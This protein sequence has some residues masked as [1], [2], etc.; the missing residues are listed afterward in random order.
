MN[1]TDAQ[2]TLVIR[3]H[4]W[5]GTG[6]CIVPGSRLS[7]HHTADPA[8]TPRRE[9]RPIQDHWTTSTRVP[10]IIRL[11]TQRASPVDVTIVGRA[12]VLSTRALVSPLVGTTEFTQERNLID[13]KSV[14]NALVR[15][16]ISSAIRGRTLTKRHTCVEIVARA[17]AGSI[18]GSAGIKLL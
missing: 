6:I 4:L 5:E 16:Q 1:V 15:A 11:V 8:F 3:H 14:V 2:M 7:I 13:V 18:R 10:L 12:R 17:S 9:I